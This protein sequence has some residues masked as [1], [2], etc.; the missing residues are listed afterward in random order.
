MI[1]KAQR[2]TPPWDLKRLLDLLAL[3]RGKRILIVG[4]VGI[5]R[6]TMG[7]VERISP[8]A[9]VPV[10]AV[11]EER[12]KMGLAANVADNT[13]TLGGE[14]LLLGVVGRDTMAV[15]FRKL[16]KAA[17]VSP[18]YLQYDATRRTILK[19]RIVS[20]R[21]QLLR[22]DYESPHP[23]SQKVEESILRMLKR[24]IRKVDGV[25]LQDY[26]K[27]MLS[28]SLVE[29]VFRESARAKKFVAVDPNAKSPVQLYRGANFMTP[30][31]REAQ[32]LSGIK[33]VDEKSLMEAGKKL[34]ALTGAPYLV[35]TR[36]KD[37]M[38][39]FRKGSSQVSL[40]PT[41]AR[42][43]Y[44]VSGAGDTVIAV[45]ALVMASGGSIEEAAFLGNVGAGVVVEKRGTATVSAAEIRTA[46]ERDP[47]LMGVSHSRA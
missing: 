2:S 5:D 42:E 3:M 32:A 6:Y 29:G 12:H 13:R 18:G 25:I 30:N 47:Y 46:M 35:I 4:D 15:E 34:L 9:P 10:V 24:V 19:E 23:I 16:L 39:I 45:M 8:E 21:Q 40:I 37:G 33:I 27:G 11:Q 38:A 1:T 31:L 41:A 22:V 28:R 7:Q 44:D 43:V 14:P 17:K 36:G 26:A 20:D